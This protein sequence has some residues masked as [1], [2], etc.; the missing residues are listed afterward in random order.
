MP[1]DIKECPNCRSR[2]IV[3]LVCQ[4][5][6]YDASM[7][8]QFQY[9]ITVTVAAANG[10]VT[11]VDN[12]DKYPRGTNLLVTAIPNATNHKQFVKW[13][14]DGVDYTSNP[15]NIY[16][17]NN[18]TIVPV[19]A[20]KKHITVN[21]WDGTK[22][23]VHSSTYGEIGSSGVDYYVDNGTNEVFTATPATHCTFVQWD[24]GITE[25]PH[26]YV[27][28]TD[29]TVSPVF[30]FIH[31]TVTVVIANEGGVIDQS[32][33]SYDEGE[34]YVVTST[35]STYFDDDKCVF[36]NV[37]KTITSHEVTITIPNHNC[38]LTW[39]FKRILHTVTY[40]LTNADG[41]KGTFKINGVPKTESGTIGIRDSEMVTLYV[42]A[43]TQELNVFTVDTVSHKDDIDAAHEYGVKV[44]GKD[45]T[46]VVDFTTV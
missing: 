8:E 11:G 35:P 5:C 42:E 13:T 43:G 44:T 36:D 9:L 26:T 14:I 33:G 3:S 6:G 1:V 4:D 16:V 24:E 41:T 30:H 2:N 18:V 45:Y 29:I 40:T 37:N 25:N 19:F 38:I 17:F 20:T 31:R 21:A 7:E 23:G 39:S 15:I 10:S 32:T 12:G 34:E 22:G 28:I 27:V 46:I